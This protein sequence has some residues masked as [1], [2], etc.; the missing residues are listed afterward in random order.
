[1]GLTYSRSEIRTIINMRLRD[2]SNTVWTATQK[3]YI[4]ADVHRDFVERTECNRNVL[5]FSI[6]DAT[7][8]GVVEYDQNEDSPT[9]TT[10]TITR[11]D[12]ENQNHYKISNCDRILHLNRWVGTAANDDGFA[13]ELHRR[14]QISIDNGNLLSYSLTPPSGYQP[15]SAPDTFRLMPALDSAGYPFKF[16][17]RYLESVVDMMTNITYPTDN[18]VVQ[19]FGSTLNDMTASG[20]GTEAGVFTVTID[21]APGTP[22]PD[23]V[24]ITKDGVNIDTGVAITTAAQLISTNRYFTFAADTGHALNDVWRFYSDDIRVPSIPLR[25]RKTFE[26]GVVAELY[27]LIGDARSQVYRA[28]YEQGIERIL[29]KVTKDASDTMPSVRMSYRGGG[30]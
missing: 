6:A 26:L 10:P 14:N 4:I 27:E 17:L 2:S 21:S 13:K 18:T 1:M 7:S 9:R 12:V 29:G 25:F 11:I 5:I 24:L 28:R 20:T 23:T 22:N 8:D 16:E 3:N 15:L 30:S 19:T